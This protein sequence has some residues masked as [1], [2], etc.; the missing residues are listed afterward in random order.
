M[1]YHIYR[2]AGIVG[3][4]PNDVDDAIRNGVQRASRTL[5][6]LDW[7]EVSEIRGTSWTGRSRTGSHDEDRFPARGA[8]REVSRYA[9]AENGHLRRF[10]NLSRPAY[11]RRYSHSRWCHDDPLRSAE[12]QQ[13]QV[14][15]AALRK[16]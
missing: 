5:R 3:S 11:Q 10:E 13:A 4:S 16:N 1:S 9:A 8:L 2:V 7:L 14:H 15:D 12:R 6:N